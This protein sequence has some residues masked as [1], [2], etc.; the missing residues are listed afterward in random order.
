MAERVYE[1]LA[2]RPTRGGRRQKK[3]PP[4]ISEADF[5]RAAAR[6]LGRYAASVAG[7]R[8]V[9]SRRARRSTAHHGGSPQDATS[10]IDL[11]VAR[12]IELGL[13]DDT[14]Y[15][16]SLVRRLRRRGQSRLQVHSQLV[17]KGVGK[18]VC[19]SLLAEISDRESE[20]VAA[21]IYARRRRLGPHR[22]DPELIRE[23]RQRDLAALGR[24]GFAPEIALSVMDTPKERS[25]RSEAP[26][27]KFPPT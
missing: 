18:D 21:Q 27:D 4:P 17:K 7:L 1:K 20:L 8:A 12:C 6:H 9:L 15:G 5:E 22:A 13:L 24:A 11:V 23:N 26:G 2:A 19:E 25:L 16:R 14:A 3:P 10:I